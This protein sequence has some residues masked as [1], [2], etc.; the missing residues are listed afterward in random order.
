M[1]YDVLPQA[2]P[3]DHGADKE[4]LGMPS[5]TNG[6]RVITTAQDFF[7]N[8]ATSSTPP[9]CSASE[10][11][12][13]LSSHPWQQPWKLRNRACFQKC[14]R[15]QRTLGCDSRGKPLVN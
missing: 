10:T 6:R 13:E 11:A 3:T 12:A 14:R 9:A 15:R 1:A 2:R 7:P 8:P 5:W 4:K